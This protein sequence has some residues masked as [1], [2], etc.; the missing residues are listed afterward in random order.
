MLQPL[1]LV[2]AERM[3]NKGNNV[4][5]KPKDDVAVDTTGGGSMSS[6]SS[7]VHYTIQYCTRFNYAS[8]GIM[9]SLRSIFTMLLHE[10]FYPY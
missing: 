9:L 10:S 1:T 4:W 3:K 6:Q 8:T 2:Q 5:V 7:Q